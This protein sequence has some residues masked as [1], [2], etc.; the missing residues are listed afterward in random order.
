[1][2]TFLEGKTRVFDIRNPH[3]PVQIFE[4]T[5]GKQVNMVSQSWDGRRV[6]FT[7]SLLANWDKK[8]EDND[9]YLRAFDW[10]GAKLTPTFDID[11]TAEK[12]GR[13]HQMRFGAR[14]LYGQRDGRGATEQLARGN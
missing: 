5:I 11:F 9:Q 10:D 12:L 14:A 7:S 8:G 2:N 6:Y 4:Q 3:A 13:P 1:M